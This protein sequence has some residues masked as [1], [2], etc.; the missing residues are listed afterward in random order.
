MIERPAYEGN[1][2]V[3]SR[4][5]KA[6]RRAIAKAD[7][8]PPQMPTDEELDSLLDLLGYTVLGT[9]IFF[10][11]T[12]PE[13]FR[14]SSSGQTNI[15][16][17]DVALLPLEESIPAMGELCKTTS[18]AAHLLE[19]YLNK[20][21]AIPTLMGAPISQTTHLNPFFLTAKDMAEEKDE[22]ERVKIAW[23]AFEKNVMGAKLLLGLAVGKKDFLIDS[24]ANVNE[25]LQEATLSSMSTQFR[26]FLLSSWASK[27]GALY[28]ALP[29]QANVLDTFHQSIWCEL[30]AKLGND[31]ASM[32][33]LN[34]LPLVGVWVLIDAGK[35]TQPG[36]SVRPGDLFQHARNLGEEWKF[37]NLQMSLI[38]HQLR[39]DKEG[40]DNV[41]EELQGQIVEF[42]ERHAKP[43]NYGILT[44]RHCVYEVLKTAIGKI[45][46]LSEII[47]CAELAKAKDDE[48][49][50]IVSFITAC[51]QRTSVSGFLLNSKVRSIWGIK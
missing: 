47:T 24:L 20:T 29:Q 1:F 51:K 6:A 17:F 2:A 46:F 28:A 18:V 27:H 12:V 14:A 4:T 34:I 26:A 39:A 32:G 30:Q 5:I 23:E 7:M 25:G 10:D 19:K 43:Y 3:A 21:Q 48:P 44:T 11:G 49:D 9:K 33:N 38:D 8:S 31:L 13:D 40:I 42:S 36:T 41:I 16:I 35:N 22:Q 50:P 45:P 15:S 37:K